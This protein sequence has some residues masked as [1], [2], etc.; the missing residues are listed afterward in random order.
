MTLTGCVSSSGSNENEIGTE[1][2]TDADGESVAF[3][4]DDDFSEFSELLAQM[5]PDVT[6][7]WSH[8]PYECVKKGSV[9]EA[10]DVQALPAVAHDLAEYWYPL[11]LATV[12]IAI[13]RD[14]TNAA[15]DGWTDLS[16]AGVPIGMP[17]ADYD[18]MHF[19]AVAYGL[20][21]MSVTKSARRFF[22]RTV[23]L[24]VELRA[25][26]NLI[27][28]PSYDAPILICYDYQAASMIKNGRNL[29]VV[30][31][32]E[33]T[34]AYKRGLLSDKPLALSE[35]FEHLLISQ[36]FRLTDG[37][38][39]TDLYA[40]AAAYAKASGVQ[41]VEHFNTVYPDAGRLFRRAVM[42][43]RIYSSADAQEH[44]LF[45]LVYIIIVIAWTASVFRRAMQK[46][47]RR[48]ALLTGFILAG[49]M[50][51]RL[52]KY[53]VIGA[54]TLSRYLWYSYYL[55]QLA[56][57][58]VGLRLASFMDKPDVGGGRL[59][60]WL[61][62]LAAVSGALLVLV[63]TNDLHNL[64][65]RLDLGS[66]NWSNDYSYGPVFWFVQ[67][68]CWAPVAAAVLMLLVKSGRNPRKARFLFPV[69]F[70]VVL[71][72]Y[73]LG[74][75]LRIPI[76]W[77]SDTTMVI[78][79]FAMMFFEA[80]MRTGLI[81]VNTKYKA[82][83]AHST[84]DM[85]IVSADGEVAVYSAALR[86]D[87]HGTRTWNYD[88]DMLESALASYPQPI[89]PDEDTFLLAAAIAGGS[90][91]WQEDVSGLNRLHAEIEESVRKLTA[92]NSVL[93]EE[94]KV[95]RDVADNNAKIQLIEQ[96]ENEIAEPLAKMSAMSEQLSKADDT[97]KETARFT[98]LLCYIKRRCNLFFRELE[99][100][101]IPAGELTV[102]MDELAGI[103]DY[104]GVKVIV[105]S[106]TA[107]SLSAR[108]AALFYG[109]FYHAIDW[110]AD[111]NCP[112]MLVNMWDEDNTVTMRIRS[113]ADAK[114]FRAD[115][116]FLASVA[117]TGGVFALKDLDDAVAISLA[118]GNEELGVRSA[119]RGGATKRASIRR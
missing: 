28:T 10:F 11:Y 37:R 3:C 36:G 5:L 55:F 107:A 68:A 65:F 27:L 7:E 76:A 44:Q 115:D 19:V 94:E 82:L 75:I 69:A 35:N 92:A 59:P 49:W 38:C 26:G 81:A 47:V 60:Q 56:L 42:H 77:E 79:L 62:A 16:A 101:R 93:A 23:D 57:P 102:Y 116:S 112:Y 99:T 113:S 87:A 1:A 80:A 72:L 105:T 2:R 96:L 9:T 20:E 18:E 64:V 103:A 12:V 71:M 48:S 58:L 41:D 98:L 73:N 95:K 104:S 70:I 108:A 24:L 88:N 13:D 45:A 4:L 14:M 53:Q 114:H 74:Y 90:A 25:D 15:I 51:A 91:L 117:S 89:Q 63:F 21:G 85:K 40:D 66:P 33:G 54:N 67:A 32:A 100:E 22:A 31:P 29:D 119:E 118:F 34:I 17:G 106:E 86:Q 52:F 110:A 78:G 61:K 6:I 109:L 83:F 50:L 8:R 97:H 39:D 46:E 30:V 43:T 111:L 84:L